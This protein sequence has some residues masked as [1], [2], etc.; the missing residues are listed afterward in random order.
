M[1]DGEDDACEKR[2]SPG[3]QPAASRR[4]ADVGEVERD[5]DQQDGKA[6]QGVVQPMQPPARRR[7]PQTEKRHHGG[8]QSSEAVQERRR[9][10]AEA[11]PRGRPRP[12]LL[13]GSHNPMIHWNKSPIKS[14][15][16]KIIRLEER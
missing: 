10:R 2:R 13:L 6:E 8:D 5:P 9:D 7:A 3:D 11:G 15:H 4:A 1:P 12:A 16:G 14:W